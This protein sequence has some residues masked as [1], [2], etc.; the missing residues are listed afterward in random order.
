MAD[1]FVVG[2]TVR[3]LA[4]GRSPA[5]IDLVT[6]ANP[7][8]TASRLADI[9]GGRVIIFRKSH[10]RVY[11][12][13][14]KTRGLML[15]ITPAR[16]GSIDADL[17]DRDFTVNAMALDIRGKR[18]VDPLDG[19]ADLEAGRLRMVSPK[20]FDN[21]PVRLLRAYRL[22]AQ[23]G[24]TI[25]EDTEDAIRAHAVSITTVAGERIRQ[26]LLKML[27]LNAAAPVMEQM[28]SAGLVIALFPETALL[29]RLAAPDG[30]DGTYGDIARQTIRELDGMAD[31]ELPN[32][33]IIR[34]AALL[35]DTGRTVVVP[36]R[37]NGT[38]VY[39]GA[40]AISAGT[41]MR[42][43]R[44]LRLSGSETTCMR[45]LVR[46]PV[47]V[48]AL[49]AARLK[50]KSAP[51]ARTRF[52]QAAE[53]YVT[54]SILLTHARYRAMH[55][56][57]PSDADDAFSRFAEELAHRYARVYRPRADDPPLINGHE[58]SAQHG[59]PAGPAMGRILNTL[60]LHQLSGLITNTAEAEALIADLMDTSP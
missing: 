57:T 42:T 56:R 47:R 3:D 45:N 54:E 39:P 16:D 30:V 50:G 13:V 25:T 51:L 4:L 1:T 33:A 53:P 17:R 32:L 41:A 35:M 18:L 20:A 22:G 7:E 8:E 37:R 55:P 29:D 28:W 59:V 43:C 48:R 31:P 60:R 52:F 23:Y 58:L 36:D 24:L 12:V 9:L 46:A 40:T 49:F 6:L 11:R 19:T 34:L 14:S 38:P 26:E 21:D 2:G 5:D 10:Y 44:R 15:D 27:S